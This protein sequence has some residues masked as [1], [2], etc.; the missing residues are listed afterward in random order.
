MATDNRGRT[1]L[2]FA[3]GNADRPASPAV[4][5]LLLSQDPAVVNSVDLEGNLPI[6]LLATRAQ[7]I[8]EDEEKD[9]CVNC[10]ECLNFYL[11]A[12]PR[13]S[14]DLLTA[15][16]SLPEWLRES[17]C[18]NP[19]V[20]KILNAKIS[21][22]FPTTVIMLDIFFYTLVI[23]MFQLAVTDYQRAI[24]NDRDFEHPQ[25][26][27]PL[28]IAVVYFIVREISQATSLASLGLFN[29][30]VSDLE[31]WLDLL[32]IFLILFWSIVMSS[33]RMMNNL[34]GFAYGAAFTMAVFWFMVLHFLQ[35]IIVGFA[36]FM[37]GVFYVVKRL[38]AFMVAL[39]IILIAF[40]QAFFTV[41]RHSESCPDGKEYPSH[42]TGTGINYPVYGYECTESDELFGENKNCTEVVDSCE[43]V[44]DQPF[45]NFAT[46]L[47]KVV[48]MMIGE[49]S[50]EYFNKGDE[51]SAVVAR[52]LYGFFMFLCVVVLANVL[53]AIVTDSYS[54]IQ[55]ERAGESSKSS[56]PLLLTKCIIHE[57]INHCQ[58]I[59]PIQ[60]WCSG[61]IGLIL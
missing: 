2:H 49:V 59:N 27:V 61:P 33:G 48:T 13:A 17:A 29:T 39:T 10:Q 52:F 32:Y 42:T 15:L 19:E 34:N 30:W 8:K 28:Y 47:A 43:P 60:R 51:L 31:N 44:I 38:A 37:G 40:A 4:V 35:S 56:R 53:I 57:K 14:A 11:V 12:H 9:K 58:P 45:C 18:L 22:R 20:Q 21:Q 6:H 3:L 26:L 55:N 46:S 24:N 54:V 36:V 50:E 23:I 5:G 7:A 16:Q 25:Y 1:P 41:F